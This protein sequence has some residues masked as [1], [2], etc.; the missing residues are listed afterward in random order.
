LH[1]APA[2]LHLPPRR[3]KSARDVLHAALYTL[4]L[5]TSL[6]PAFSR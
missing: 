5:A 6:P 1:G 3:R 2:G 4:G